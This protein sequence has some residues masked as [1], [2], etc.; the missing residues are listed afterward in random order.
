M[1]KKVL[2]AVLGF[3]LAGTI[4]FLV[5]LAAISYFMKEISSA[6]QHMLPT[7]GSVTTQILPANPSVTHQMLPVNPSVD[8]NQIVHIPKTR[9]QIVHENSKQAYI[10]VKKEVDS[11]K[12]QYKKPPECYDM[13][14]DAT[15]KH[16]ANEFIRARKVYEASNN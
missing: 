2:G 8:N 14:N 1:L 5:R 3:L 6:T 12:A 10:Q 15:R 11:F 7:N 13:Q 9:E 16:C 4:I